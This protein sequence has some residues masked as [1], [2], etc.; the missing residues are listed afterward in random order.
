MYYNQLRSGEYFDATMYEENW[1][2]LGYDDS[3]WAP[4]AIDETPPK[5]KMRL[6]RA[7]PIRALAEYPTVSVLK[8]GRKHVFDIGQ[9]IA[10][11][12]RIRVCQPSGTELILRYAEEI[13]GD[14]NLKLN[15]LDLFQRDAAPFQTDRLICGDGETVWHPQF[16]YKGF[17]YVE[18]EGLTVPPSPDISVITTC[19]ERRISFVRTNCSIKFTPAGSCLRFPICTMC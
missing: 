5:G 16:T 8:N 1:N 15:N 4:A 3:D 7:E 10:G 17:R 19:A 11:Y 9:N 6:C 13:D 2:T 14:N 12:A 18:I